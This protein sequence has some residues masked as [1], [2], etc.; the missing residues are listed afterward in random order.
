MARVQQ[1]ERSTIYRLIHGL[2]PAIPDD[3]YQARAALIVAQIEGLAL[4]YAG[5][6][7]RRFTLVQLDT[8]A[9]RMF[10]ALATEP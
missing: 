1:R 5:K 3:E 7:R 4:Q 10:M 9:R 6:G 2:S 8:L